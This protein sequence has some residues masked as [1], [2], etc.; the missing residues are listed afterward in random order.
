MGFADFLRKDFQWAA[1]SNEMTN[2]R[3]SKRWEL[4]VRER[5]SLLIAVLSLV[6]EWHKKWLADMTEKD[7]SILDSD[8]KQ[9]VQNRVQ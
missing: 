1:V 6:E 8:R 4:Q 7:E 9:E 3:G 2:E 5:E